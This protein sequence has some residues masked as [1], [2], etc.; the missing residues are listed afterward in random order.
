MVAECHDGGDHH[1]VAGVDAY[2][3]DVL[4]AADG[5]GVVVG[6]PHDLKFD[7]LVAL[8]GLLHQNL[9]DGGES[10]GVET[11]FHQLV[12]IV[13]EAAAGAAESKGGTK[14]HRIADA[15]GGFLGFLQRVGN[16]GGDDRLADG[17]AQLLEKLPILGALDG[18]AGGAQQPD[19]AFP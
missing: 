10:E 12:F 5:D 16:L 18:L 9:M 11:D 3:V 17:L 6:V 15:P 7:L 4:H 19:P 1:A 8:D 14:H 13:G 2:G